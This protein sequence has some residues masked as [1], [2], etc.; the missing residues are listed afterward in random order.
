MI[1]RLMRFLLFFFSASV[2]SKADAQRIVIMLQQKQ[3]T[4]LRGLSVV[5]DN[6]AWVS[7]SKGCVG[8]TTD[9]GKS[10]HWQIV[11][12]YEKADF[13]DIEAF[14]A[15]EA[16]IMSSGTPALI[17][18]TTNGGA[19]WNLAYRNDNKAYF[20]DAMDFYKSK[21]GWVL[22]DPI[23]S[24]FLLLETND[25]GNTWVERKDIAPLAI[26]DEAAFAA[27]GT[28]LRTVGNKILIVTGGS[29]SRII[30]IKGKKQQAL[31]LPLKQGLSS[32]G[33]FSLA[34]SRKHYVITG[35]DYNNDKNSE[36]ISCIINNNI[37]NEPHKGPSGYQSGVEHIG[38]INY[39]STG[40]SGSN[41]STDNGKNWVRIDTVSFNVCRK[42]KKG[43]LVLLAGN[44]GKIAVLK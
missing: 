10:W 39:L 13:R 28:C 43:K 22:G 12:G 11:A 19:S 20:F 18:K 16:I 27:S 8:I 26:K 4:S 15:K 29:V 31:Q 1:L 38:G 3:S 42:A 23:D 17:L 21:H 40:T 25:A 35:G 7:G 6:V 2:I 30:M 32:Q 9:G 14:S 36:L 34:V 37:I 44:N 33:A 24:Q 41:L 5:D